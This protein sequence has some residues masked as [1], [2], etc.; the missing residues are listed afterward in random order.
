M[1]P[2]VGSGGTVRG[3]SMPADD[4]MP[5]WAA[6]CTPGRTPKCGVRIEPDRAAV[7]PTGVR[8]GRIPVQW[9][10]FRPPPSLSTPPSGGSQ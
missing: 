1:R 5:C 6:H 3:D 4:H 9:A 7:D 10:G 8:G 2:Q